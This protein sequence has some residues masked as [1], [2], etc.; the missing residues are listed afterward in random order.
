MKNLKIL[1]LGQHLYIYIH[2]KKYKNK[3]PKHISEI[4]RHNT[5]K[6]FLDL[7]LKKSESKSNQLV[8][9]S[10]QLSKYIPPQIHDALFEGKY[11]TE[12]KTQ[13]GS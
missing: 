13:E 6:K 9:I 12:I 4:H 11:D 7:V 1:Y 10:S 2:L 8:D 3:D 5:T